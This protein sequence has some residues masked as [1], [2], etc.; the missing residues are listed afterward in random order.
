MSSAKP[1]PQLDTNE[2]LFGRLGDGKL[3]QYPTASP[4]SGSGGYTAS[5]ASGSGG[6][7]AKP[8]ASKVRAGHISLR[9]SDGK[10]VDIKVKD[11][12]KTLLRDS[13]S[14]SGFANGLKRGIHSA[15]EIQ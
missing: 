11:L 13:A 2:I 14:S 9:S 1:L 6:Y 8:E 10:F 5:S 12:V 15:L 7:T 4:A 3:V